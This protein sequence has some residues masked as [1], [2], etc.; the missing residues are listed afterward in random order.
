LAKIIYTNSPG[1]LDANQN[2]WVYNGLDCCVTK[3]VW[4]KI[5]RPDYAKNTYHYLKSLQGP[6]LDMMLR[7]LRVDRSKRDLALAEVNKLIDRCYEIGN[8]LAPV[9]LER[10]KYNPNSDDQVMEVLYDRMG[11]PEQLTKDKKTEA[12]KRTVDRAAL[13]KLSAYLHARPICN[14]TLTIRDLIKE[15][16]VLNAKIDDDNYMRC[17]YNGAGTET[18]RLSSSKNAFHGGTNF[19]NITDEKRDMFVSEPGF[20]FGYTDLEQAESRVVGALAYGATGQHRY[21]D[22]CESGDLH[23]TV[24][25]MVW[26]RLPWTGEL[27]KDK[28]IAER[29]FYRHFSYR[30]MAKRGGHGT[31]YYG[32]AWT[33]AKNLKVEQKLM[34]EFQERYFN[35][36]PEI[37]LWHVHVATR[38]QLDG[39]LDTPWGTR[40]HFLGRRWDDATLREAIAHGPQST[41]G[42]LENL[43]MRKLWFAQYHDERFQELQFRLRAQIHDAVIFSFKQEKQAIL[44]PLV[45]ELSKIPIQ[46]KDR[47]VIIPIDFKFGWNWRTASANNPYGLGKL[48]DERDYI[49]PATVHDRGFPGIY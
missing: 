48:P 16:S 49:S 39:F 34:E 47:S 29:P 31:N 1:K 19:Q 28:A 23:T 44:I 43:I 5:P 13:E 33:M 32:T 17:S 18:L 26:P 42:I 36:F 9:L 21:L 46:V 25:R 38:L 22:A 2:L 35:E 3:E 30:D 7:G 45:K 27:K 20:K 10:A 6:L 15:R 11:L 4:E 24:A 37:R 14:L 40:R 41:I 12:K 8:L